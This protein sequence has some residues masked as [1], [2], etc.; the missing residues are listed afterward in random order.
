[1]SQKKELPADEPENFSPVD[2]D[3]WGMIVI[4]VPIAGIM[5][6]I[7]LAIFIPGGLK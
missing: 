1:M 2:E 4:L 6:W 3:P 7:A 5:A